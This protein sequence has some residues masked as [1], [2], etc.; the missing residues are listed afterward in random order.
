MDFPASVKLGVSTN[1][2]GRFDQSVPHSPRFIGSKDRLEGAKTID[3]RQN[4]LTVRVV[5]IL[6][7]AHKPNITSRCSQKEPK[8][9]RA[10]QVPE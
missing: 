8:L 2:V 1:H 6:N 3:L 9:A 5:T 7:A 10:R 4:P